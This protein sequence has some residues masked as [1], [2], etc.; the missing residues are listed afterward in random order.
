[1]YIVTII[2]LFFPLLFPSSMQ[3]GFSERFYS[4]KISRAKN[5]RGIIPKEKKNK[6]KEKVRKNTYK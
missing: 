4:G 3:N 1:M 2:F 6:N 5:E